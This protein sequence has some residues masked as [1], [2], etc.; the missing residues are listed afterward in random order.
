MEYELISDEDYY[1]LPPEATKR[2]LAI[3]QVCRRNMTAIVSNETSQSYNA[4]IRT[5]YMTIVSAT[6]EELGVEGVNYID[7]YDSID[8][9]LAEFMRR[10]SGVTAKLRLRHSPQADELSVRLAN[11]TKGLI[12]HELTS[13]GMLSPIVNFPM[14]KRKI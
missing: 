5:Q 9:D 13:F 4:L 8:Q 10:V 2:F 3:E 12:E 11:K 6:A 14:K 1:H 7:N